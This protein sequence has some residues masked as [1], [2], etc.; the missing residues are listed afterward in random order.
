[1]FDEYF[2]TPQLWPGPGQLC[3]QEKGKTSLKT[4][5]VSKSGVLGETGRTRNK[6]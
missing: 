4:Q 3:I 1:M 2:D 6:N 5:V